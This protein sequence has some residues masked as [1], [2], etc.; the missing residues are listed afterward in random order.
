[1]SKFACFLKGFWRSMDS[2]SHIKSFVKPC[3]SSLLPATLFGGGGKSGRSTRLT[4]S[5]AVDSCLILIY[6][7]KIWISILDCKKKSENGSIPRQ[8][9]RLVFRILTRSSEMVSLCLCLEKRV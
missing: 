2:C 7:H 8:M 9:Y 4:H 3:G 6:A 5:S 1:M